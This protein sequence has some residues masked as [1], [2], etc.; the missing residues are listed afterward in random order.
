MKLKHFFIFSALSLWGAVLTSCDDEKQ[1]IIDDVNVTEEQHVANILCG[2]SEWIAQCT[3]ADIPEGSYEYVNRYL[4][5]NGAR[6]WKFSFSHTGAF[7][8]EVP[9]DVLIPA[10]SVKGTWRLSDKNLIID[11][12]QD[13]GSVFSFNGELMDCVSNYMKIK[14]RCSLL[15]GE[16]YFE[17]PY[18]ISGYDKNL[19]HPDIN[20]VIYS[21]PGED[22]YKWVLAGI[23]LSEAYCEMQK[24]PQA[25]YRSPVTGEALALAKDVKFAFHKD[26][27][28]SIVISD[29]S[30]STRYDGKWSIKELNAGTINS[31][32][33]IT[34][35]YTHPDAKNPDK[36]VEETLISGKILAVKSNY[37]RLEVKSKQLFSDEG[38]KSH[39]LEFPFNLPDFDINDYLN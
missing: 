8:L 38:Q 32:H 26:G 21:S 29:N 22:E 10:R 37:L 12:R 4:I 13:D 36:M 2:T 39:I 31:Y 11:G 35:K 27:S 28:Y 3:P 9:A 15:S 18:A 1:D 16:Y 20:T 33:S 14:G 6:G 23:E 7:M 34:L 25:L 17:F 19:Y 30:S 24:Y 5:D